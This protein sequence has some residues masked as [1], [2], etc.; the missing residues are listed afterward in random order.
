M[1]DLKKQLIRLGSTNPELQPHIKKIL[2]NLKFE[3]GLGEDFKKVRA[4]SR[5][6]ATDWARGYGEFKN[7]IL[8]VKEAITALNKASGTLMP[9]NLRSKDLDIERLA[10]VK[11]HTKMQNAMEYITI[12]LRELANME[13]E[14]KASSSRFASTKTSNLKS[15]GQ[16]GGR[17]KTP[18][19]KQ[20]ASEI[21][22]VLN[23]QGLWDSLEW[24][25]WSQSGGG[26]DPVASVGYSTY[27]GSKNLSI[28]VDEED[29]V[30]A[31]VGSTRK[32][33]PDPYQAATWLG[34][35]MLTG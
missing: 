20:K 17:P 18:W 9:V 14:Y 25:Y 6:T 3:V 28:S 4:S 8:L 19:E 24:E 12:G 23:R 2:A 33:F 27:M 34:R 31:S 15:Y 10:A 22:S 32:D 7:G 35:K 11:T 16:S 5:K 13:R 1:T 26:V 30:Y 21:R 29:Y